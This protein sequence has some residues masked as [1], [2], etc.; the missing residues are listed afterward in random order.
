MQ[1][2]VNVEISQGIATITF[3]RPKTLNA[4]TTEDYN[5]FAEALWDID[6]RDDV[7]VT[8]WQA[9][10]RMFCAGTDVGDP[11]GAQSE[12][13]TQ[14]EAFLTRVAR[15]NTDPSMALA[16]HSKILVAALNGPAFGIAAAFLGHFDFIYCLPETYI[17]VPFTFLGI[18]SEAGSSVTFMRRMGVAKANEALIFGKK[19]TAEELLACGFVNKIFPKQSAESF[20]A[21][22]RKHLL[23]ELRDLEPGALLTVKKLLRRAIQESNDPD[24]A[25][26][27]ES[28]AQA[29]R[30]AT[31]IPSQRFAAVARKELKHKL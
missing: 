1:P 7:L 25:I 27:R 16:S 30:F 5:A 17:S 26:M 23:E 20:H 31:G 22:V 18:I 29:E 14:R 12:R 10:G 13:L 19:I 2:G 11:R 3:N 6:K 9:T 4:I 24:A 15:A 21:A 8:V 28:Y